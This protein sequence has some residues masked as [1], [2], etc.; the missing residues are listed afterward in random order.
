MEQ[1]LAHSPK[2]GRPAQT[3]AEHIGNVAGR[4]RANAEAAASYYNGARNQFI[5]EVV[6]AATYHD[7]GK[8][9]D[10]N[11]RVLRVESRQPLPIRHEDAGVA[12][13]MRLKRRESVILVQAHHQGLFS[14]ENERAKQN[15]VFRFPEV[16]D[17]VDSK[18]EDYI[19]EHSQAECQTLDQL[20]CRPLHKDGFRRR[21]ALSCLVDADYGDT[22]RHYEE[23]QETAP[24]PLRWQERLNALDAYVKSLPRKS[25]ARDTLR[26]KVYHACRSADT[27]S[28]MRSCD[29]PVGSGKTT[30]V[31]AFLLQVARERNLRHIFV[32]LPY[33]NIIKQSVETYRKALVLDGEDPEA[34]VAEHHHQVD[35]S[36]LDLRHLATLWKAPIIVTTAVQFFETLGSHQPARLRKLHELPGSA[37]FIDETHAAMPAHL[38][39]QMWKW[40]ETWCG[41]WGGHVVFASG[42]LPRFWRLQEYV[43]PPKTEADIP[44]IIP[45]TL[46]EELVAAEQVRIRVESIPE[47][48]TAD[49]LIKAVMSENGPRLLIVNTVQSAAVI[50][51]KMKKSGYDVLHLSTALA[52]IH[53]DV[54]M[55]RVKERLRYKVT[56]WTLVAT[57]CVEAGMDFSFR[58]GFRESASTASFIQVGGRVSRGDEYQD[59]KTWDFRLVSDGFITGNPSLVVSQR[60]LAEL[61]KE[62]KFDA[63]TSSDLALEAMKREITQGLLDRANKLMKKENEMEYPTVS[64]LCRVITDQSTL[65]LVNSDL[66][67]A[68][69]KGEKVPHLRLLRESVRVWTSKIERK[70][71][72]LS[73]VLGYEG[74]PDALY[75][76]DAAYDPDF[77]GYMA[78]VL[79][80]LA[81]LKLGAFIA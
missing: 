66:A 37:V 50:A 10:E 55:N 13:F 57:S 74:D 68:V 51:N 22:A 25:P 58:T 48:L 77:L 27:L 60:V 3:Y 53:R 24:V 39:L 72:P 70:Q 64:E 5:D 61:L 7:L 59:A 81:G 49:E 56:D 38:W 33:V 52:P 45:A 9:D 69:R 41:E 30:A 63:D 21:V 8:L 11:Q 78:G 73:L 31:M 65:V 32:V 79:P 23:E 4:A 17:H 71:L 80:I 36:D 19:A 12:E 18:L 67:K 2:R 47:A 14:N 40:L 42:S 62:N 34:V 6:A 29:A 43:D 15:R 46:R 28:S 16:A 76:W 75:S 54:I 26:D 44:D 1:P 20:D 35:F